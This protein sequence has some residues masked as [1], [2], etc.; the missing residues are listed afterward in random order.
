MCMKFLRGSIAIVVLFMLLTTGCSEFIESS[1]ENKK[2]VLLAP[3]DSLETSS[4]NQKFWW[5]PVEHALYY[6]LQVVTPSFDSIGTL[7]VDTLVSGHKFELTLEPGTYEWRLRAENG[8]SRSLYTLRSLTIHESSIRLQQV[9]SISPGSQFVT[10]KDEVTYKWNA[11]FG[12]SRYRLQIDTN[13]FAND[14]VLFFNSTTANL[15]FSVPF[16]GDNQ[17]QWRV[18]AEN[19]STES[20]WS[21][22][23]RITFDKTPPSQVTLIS[24][25]NN[26]ASTR[27]VKL[28]WN[29]VAG[30]KRYEI[31]VLKSDST[32]VFSSSF[33]V[34]ITSTTYA[35]N[36]GDLNDV[37]FWKVRALDEAGNRGAF[38]AIRSFTIQQ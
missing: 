31:L 17:Y 28:Q 34:L 13:N 19:D 9:Q 35:F 37:L 36:G 2:I 32:T 25:A 3:G 10:N 4:Y 15:E 29:A 5:E 12:A 6:R 14:S 21:S 18:R 27:P 22:I 1:V 8:S 23:Q 7:V 38:S 16:D 26:S 11:L 24:P 30:A 20:R 33:P